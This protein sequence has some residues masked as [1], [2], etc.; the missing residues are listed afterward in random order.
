[1]E[2]CPKSLCPI[3]IS[4]AF[5]DRCS[6]EYGI[7]VLGRELVSP[8]S[9]PSSSSSSLQ[10]PDAS[11]L[12]LEFMK[13]SRRDATEPVKV[14]MSFPSTKIRT[15]YYGGKTIHLDRALENSFVAHYVS[16]KL[17]GSECPLI[18]QDFLAYRQKRGIPPMPVE[19]FLKLGLHVMF[20]IQFECSTMRVRSTSTPR[21]FA[22]G[23]TQVTTCG[24]GIML[25]RSFN[26]APIR[27]GT[28][29]FY[30]LAQERKLN[31]P[32]PGS[33][34]DPSE[35]PSPSGRSFYAHG[36]AAP[37][38]GAFTER[39]KQELMQPDKYV[40]VAVL[41]EIPTN[42]FL[43]APSQIHCS[44]ESRLAEI[45]RRCQ[46]KRGV[47]T[48]RYCSLMPLSDIG[49]TLVAMARYILDIFLRKFAFG[50]NQYELISRELLVCKMLTSLG[51][52]RGLLMYMIKLI[53][54][55]QVQHCNQRFTDCNLLQTG[56]I[57]ADKF[58]I[59]NAVEQLREKQLCMQE[60]IP[61]FVVR[62]DL[63]SALVHTVLSEHASK[64]SE[65]MADSDLKAM[66]D[67]NRRFQ[68]CYTV[69]R[70][71][72][73]PASDSQASAS[74]QPPAADIENYTSQI[75]SLKP[76]I[77]IQK[78]CI[79]DSRNSALCVEEAYEVDEK[80]QP[81]QVAAKT[82]LEEL[83]TL[84]GPDALGFFQFMESRWDHPGITSPSSSFYF[85]TTSKAH[86]TASAREQPWNTASEHVM[87]AHPSNLDKR[88]ELQHSKLS[89]INFSEG[90][91]ASSNGDSEQKSSSDSNSDTSI[92]MRARYIESPPAS[93][94]SPEFEV[95]WSLWI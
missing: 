18:N 57:P 29:H 5:L 51:E 60:T 74:Q 53:D 36:W 33:S 15:L 34:P 91:P 80:S 20:G 94:I 70:P 81:I 92:A 38:C 28:D 64:L 1:M 87:F 89:S 11:R 26:S 90:N 2:L 39:E 86:V 88:N 42:S 73:Q 10:C 66:Q 65:A 54:A 22:N 95:D 78:Q 82:R 6:L 44:S 84:I 40:S 50:R 76:V 85:S 3:T 83:E 43:M 35:N 27:F 72:Q 4:N 21:H 93:P 71:Q 77:D 13:L 12:V 48:G 9:S 52:E 75:G 63:E 61:I 68:F 7:P 32:T 23:M 79:I 25:S 14:W 30:R 24:T 59:T 46:E 49:L 55:C 47:E 19:L 62:S 67:P 8:S 58:H 69:H 37:G 17:A 45:R 16:S 41:P 56:C 31:Q